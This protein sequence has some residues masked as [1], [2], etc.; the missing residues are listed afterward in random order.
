M[1]GGSG[2]G[3]PTSWGL[4][5]PVAGRESEKL[6]HPIAGHAGDLRRRVADIDREDGAR[7]RHEP[8][9]FGR[10]TVRVRRRP[11]LQKVTW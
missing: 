4:R 11:C 7:V 3:K 9:D 6:L 1:V 10:F 8:A 5:S 2:M